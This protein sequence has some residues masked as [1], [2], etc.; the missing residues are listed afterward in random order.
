MAQ[1]KGHPF[2]I[3][4]VGQPLPREDTLDADDHVLARGSNA[5]QNRFGGRRQILMTQL[6]ATLI[7]ATDGHGLGR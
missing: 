1:D 7:E 6:R 2:L 4:E 3:T 5:A